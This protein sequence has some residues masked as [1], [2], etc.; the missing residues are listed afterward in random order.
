MKRRTRIIGI[1]AVASV[2]IGA[3]LVLRDARGVARSQGWAEFASPDRWCST[4]TDEFIHSADARERDPATF[5][6]VVPAREPESLARLEQ[7]PWV[8]V[9]E[10][11]VTGLTGRP[12]GGTGGRLVLL[13]ALSWDTPYGGFTVSWRPGAVRVNRGCLG[14]HLLPVVRR[15][16]V[17]RLPDVP[18][19]VFVDLGM[20]E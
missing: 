18:A 10:P 1:M 19:E 5:A 4:P 14:T 7:S 9:S 12:L 8:E 17:A 11:E 13:R 2:A 16:V 20:A 3:A 6:V 15:A